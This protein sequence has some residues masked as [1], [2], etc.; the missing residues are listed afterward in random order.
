MSAVRLRARVDGVVQ[1]VGFRP[2]TYRLA[3][4]LRLGGF[5]RN[6]ERGV[7][8]EVEGPG[9]AVEAFR[10]RLGAEA[11]PLAVVE[12]V[13]WRAVPAAGERRFAIVESG[14][15]GGAEAPVAADAATCDAC[16]RE[17][18]DPQDRRYR[19]PFTNCT[20]C[21]PRLTIVCAVP[22]DRARTTMAGFA[23]CDA[24]RAEYEDPSDRRYHA[25]PNACPECGP[26]VWV[27][28]ADVA[29]PIAHVA[30]A[31][32]AG[33]IT[34]VKGLGGY[35][36]ACRADDEAAVARL[37]ARK[38]REAKPFALMARCPGRRRAPRAPRRP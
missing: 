24:C 14:R 4:E 37:R 16:L 32:D 38:H 23:M 27:D 6:D 15:G 17:L 8:L 1:G 30:A 7:E 20:D 19:Y 5:V 12:A 10:R 35:H 11:P 29:D 34:A 18:F 36:L 3:C 22:Y 31:L 9:E 25:E 28:G 13:A 33:A 26:R 2:Y 21:G